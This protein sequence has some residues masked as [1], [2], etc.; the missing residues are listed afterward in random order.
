MPRSFIAIEANEEVRNS[1]NEVQ[2]ELE[3]TGA[4][5]KLVR[6]ENIHMT[7]RFLGDISE[8]RVGLFEDVINKASKTDPFQIR[9]KGLGVFPD[10]GFIRVVWAG[11]SEGSEKV[12]SL[13]REVD[14]ELDKINHP[15][16]DKEFT[17]HFT[18]ARVKSGK[19]KSE[20]NS[21]VEDKSDEEWGIVKV[22][23]IELKE[24]ELTPK[25]PIYTTL[26]KAELG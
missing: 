20:I 23:R 25:G 26:E 8:D 2:K 16:D 12:T 11:V 21:I 15:P 9:V 6:S 19:A 18:I 13:R 24:S 22:D 10:P 17:P 7:L 1:L 5:L 14:Q 4:D 3:Q